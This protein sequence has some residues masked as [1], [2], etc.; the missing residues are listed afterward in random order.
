VLYSDFSTCKKLLTI[1]WHGMVEIRLDIVSL[2]YCV[3][4]AYL[5][6]SIKFVKKIEMC[7]LR[8]F[9]RCGVEGMAGVDALRTRVV[10]PT[11]NGEKK[12]ERATEKKRERVRGVERIGTLF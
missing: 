2:A 12:R 7:D 3:A 6:I 9:T 1:A 4:D 8:R 10:L 11:A 5:G